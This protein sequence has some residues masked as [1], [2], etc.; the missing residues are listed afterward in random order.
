M[1][2]IGAEGICLGHLLRRRHENL[3]DCSYSTFMSARFGEVTDPKGSIELC[4][5]EILNVPRGKAEGNTE[6]DYEGKQNWLF[7]TRSVIK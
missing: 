7:P 3:L 5:P 6:V 1:S 4:F 2:G